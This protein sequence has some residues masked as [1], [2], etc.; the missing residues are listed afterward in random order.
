MSYYITPLACPSN[1]IA[2]EYDTGLASVVCTSGKCKSGYGRKTDKL[3]YG[4]ILIIYMQNCSKHTGK[5]LKHVV[6]CP[7]NNT[8]LKQYNNI[9]KDILP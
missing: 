3:C 8:F 6:L 4:K 9:T 7:L 5:T 1:C 2:C